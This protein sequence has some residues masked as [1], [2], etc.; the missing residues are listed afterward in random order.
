[1]KLTKTTKTYK[2]D[3]QQ[4]ILIDAEGKTLGRL[5][6]KISDTLRGKN[7]ACFTP[8]TDCGDYV[9]VINAE[10]IKLTGKKLEDKQY[11]HHTGYFGGLKTVNAEKMI[12]KNPEK[13]LY[14]AVKGM[15]PKNKLS[16][17][18][19]KKLKIYKGPEH[20]HKAQNPKEKN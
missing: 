4:W 1:M 10:K 5:A 17:Q 15:M 7:K 16:N 9:I 3:N 20:N 2:K 11:Y 18:I 6:T 12:E 13:I 19:I 8:N 14:T